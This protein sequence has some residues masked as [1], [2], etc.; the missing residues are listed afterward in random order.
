M[1]T[2]LIA[3]GSNAVGSTGGVQTLGGW[4]GG[5]QDT[6][7]N[8]PGGGKEKA[9]GGNGYG[10]GAGYGNYGWDDFANHTAQGNPYG[11]TQVSNLIGGSGGGGGNTKGGGSGGGAIELIAHGTGNLVLAAGS[12]ISVN[13]GDTSV[14]SNGGG[15]GSAGSIRLVGASVVNNGTLSATGM[16]PLAVQDGSGGRIVFCL[17][18]TSPS[19]RD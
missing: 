5:N 11:D 3:D 1:A 15:S 12:K 2:Q 14:T 13:G 10:G 17:L 7:G 9:D 4:S 16:A 6:D 19:P 8:G 18:Y